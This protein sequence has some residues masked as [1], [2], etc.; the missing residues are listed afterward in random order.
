M[1]H[2]PMGFHDST[3]VWLRE[4]LSEVRKMTMQKG[5][6]KPLP[7]AAI[8]GLMWSVL[9]GLGPLSDGERSWHGTRLLAVGA[10]PML[11]GVRSYSL[12]VIQLG[13]TSQVS[14]ICKLTIL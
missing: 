1:M 14:W 7:S 4:M 3:V 2:C 5:W 6:A 11:V 8:L 12:S 13:N 10:Q 9:A